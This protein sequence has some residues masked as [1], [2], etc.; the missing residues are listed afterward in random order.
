MRTL[1]GGNQQKVLLAR[2]LLT[3]PKVL[4]LDEPTRGVDVGAKAEIYELIHQLSREGVAI[5]IV[6]SE[7]PEVLNI[8]D[9]IAV[10]NAGELACILS[11]EEASEE[12]IMFYATESRKPME[13]V[14]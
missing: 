6:S 14:A 9:R 11:R 10:F 8:S 13:K 1:S 3:K 2:S 4:L 7:L 5:I 12:K